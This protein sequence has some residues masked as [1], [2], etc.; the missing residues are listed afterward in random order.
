MKVFILTEGGRGIGFGHITRC[1]A[2]YDAFEWNDI[3]PSFLINA[4]SSVC[5]ILKGNKY[6]IFDWLKEQE[7]LFAIIKDADV[8]VVDSYLAKSEFYKKISD[9]VRVPVYIDDNKRL[10]YPGGVV[11][12]GSIFANKLGYPKNKGTIYLLGPR[13]M[14]LRKEFWKMP[15]KKIN[16]DFK[17]VLITFGGDDS[18]EITPKILKFLSGR[19]PE[20]RKVVIVGKGF[21][22]IKKIEKMSGKNTELIYYPDTEKM[23]QLMLRSDIVVSAGGQTLYELARLGTPVIAVGVADNQINN[24]NGLEKA[25]AIKCAGRWDD[26]DI[27]LKIERYMK[28]LEDSVTRAGMSRRAVFC[29]DGNGALRVAGFILKKAA[30][31]KW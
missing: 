14:P 25:G 12:N 5:T 15:N 18:K 17:E 13:Y 31:N 4:D 30:Y 1:A 11:V 19:Y 22:G 6:K 28:Y 27:L 24:L 8:V 23:K 21:K 29:V 9:A 2:I 7:K 16:K 3:T 10:K 26:P 20:C